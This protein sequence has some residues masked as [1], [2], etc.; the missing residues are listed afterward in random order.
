MPWIVS[1]AKI[2]AVVGMEIWMIVKPMSV[3]IGH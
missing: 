2:L 3:V 1:L